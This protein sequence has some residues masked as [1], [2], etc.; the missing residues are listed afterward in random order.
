MGSALIMKIKYIFWIAAA[1]VGR[2]G[3]PATEGLKTRCWRKIAIAL[4]DQAVKTRYRL[5]A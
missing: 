1:L 3:L 4:N 5:I 2:S